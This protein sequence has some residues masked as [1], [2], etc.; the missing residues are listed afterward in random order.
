[1]VICLNHRWFRIIIACN[2]KYAK[3][4]QQHF[5]FGTNYIKIV[6]HKLKVS[7]HC[8][9]HTC[10][11]IKNIYHKEILGT[12]LIHFHIKLHM[13]SSNGSFTIMKPKDNSSLHAA[14]IFCMLQHKISQQKLQIFQSSITAHHCGTPAYVVL[15]YQHTVSWICHVVYYWFHEITVVYNG[16]TCMPNLVEISRL[17]QIWNERHTQTAQWSQN[18]TSF[19]QEVK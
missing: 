18:S 17:V 15:L 11:L 9:V 1:M 13:P 2:C 4:Q 3:K 6:R 19:L 16:V 14:T 8:H 5:L 12:F 10:C 7:Y